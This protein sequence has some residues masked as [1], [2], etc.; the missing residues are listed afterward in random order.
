M[1]TTLVLPGLLPLLLAGCQSAPPAEPTA[2]TSPTPTNAA[3]A[4]NEP[5]VASVN[6][7]G[8]TA[9]AA[10]NGGQSVPARA[11]LDAQIKKLEE[12]YDAQIAKATDP[13]E[14]AALEEAKE[15]VVKGMRAMADASGAK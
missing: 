3:P 8:N 10:T 14:R 15:K 13:Q 1:K 9:N 12:G 2:S 4:T 7:P 5:V 11:E 6:V